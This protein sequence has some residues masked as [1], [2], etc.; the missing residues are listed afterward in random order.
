MDSISESHEANM[1]IARLKEQRIEVEGKIQG[2]MERHSE[3]KKMM[4]WSG[5]IRERAKEII[6]AI[7]NLSPSAKR[8][9]LVECFGPERITVRAVTKSDVLSQEDRKG[10]SKKVLAEPPAGHSK[11]FMIDTVIRLDH[12]MRG[13]RYLEE[14]GRL[15]SL[16][17]Y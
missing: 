11:G 12:L 14:S 4:A 17:P 6:K 7:K 16:K 8:E 9:M 15:N 13:I 1:T 10:L 3:L 5:S 2:I